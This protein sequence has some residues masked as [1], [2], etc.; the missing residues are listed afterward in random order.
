MAQ[1]LPSD[2][3]DKVDKWVPFFAGGQIWGLH[4]IGGDS[5]P[6]F[7]PWTGFAVFSAYAAAAIIGGAF[8]FKKRDA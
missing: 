5:T 2:W 1:F 8:L 3:A 4:K 6:M 7:S